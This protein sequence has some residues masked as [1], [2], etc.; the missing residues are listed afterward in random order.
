[1]GHTQTA[2]VSL[3]R[4][5]SVYGWNAG[6]ALMSMLSS[7]WDD[8]GSHFF[9][10]IV[11]Y[12]C[13][14]ESWE[15]FD[16][17]WNSALSEFHVSRAHMTDY[18]ARQGEF[19]GWPEHKRRDFVSRLATA[20]KA[21]DLRGI[22]ASVQ[23]A[24]LDICNRRWHHNYSPYAVAAAL[25]MAEFKEYFGEH[26]TAECFLDRIDNGKKE[27]L[28]AEDILTGDWLYRE[29][30]SEEHVSWRH[31]TKSEMQRN[32][33]GTEAADFAAWE[34]RTNAEGLYGVSTTWIG[35]HWSKSRRSA[36]ALID[37]APINGRVHGEQELDKLYGRIAGRKDGG[38]LPQ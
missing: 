30:W 27:L 3:Y 9:C 32:I 26:A 16:E 5:L 7:Y 19:S 12:V 28:A 13:K 36:V 1:M 14:V 23:I 17:K 34:A 24:A 22:G 33:R 38:W 25:C 4:W 37:A 15:A 29:W 31:L 20:I 10:T 21:A 6:Q 8:S 35:D 18:V 11:G 2:E